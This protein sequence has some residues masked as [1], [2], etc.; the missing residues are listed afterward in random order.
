M[1]WY[2]VKSI[3]N[4]IIQPQFYLQACTSGREGEFNLN[5]C[6]S[7]F[8]TLC[9]I[10]ISK[11]DVM[12]RG[13]TCNMDLSTLPWHPHW[14]WFIAGWWF[15]C[16]VPGIPPPWSHY[17]DTPSNVWPPHWHT[18]AENRNEVKNWFLNK[19]Y[20]FDELQRD[21]I[22]IN[23]NNNNNKKQQAK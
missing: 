23:N 4:L 9:C 15:L 10:R 2:A 22:K 21:L 16:H 8:S 17:E 7:S 3:Q 6:W 13:R 14:W 19:I 5:H 1:E 12:F 11:T 20:K 18:T